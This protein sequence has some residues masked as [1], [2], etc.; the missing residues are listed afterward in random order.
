[1]ALTYSALGIDTSAVNEI[2]PRTGKEKVF[3]LPKINQQTGKEELIYIPKSSRL[4]SLYIVGAT[5]TGKSGL[6][7]NLIVQDI[8]QGVG[9]CVLDPH[10]GDLI[11]AVL[12][13]MDR[14]EEDVIL[15]DITD[16]HY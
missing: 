6:I 10:G 7:E 11:D 16:Y 2:D 1:M 3:Y 9:V 4:Q 8:K 15:L 13:R 14:R 12:T 5:G